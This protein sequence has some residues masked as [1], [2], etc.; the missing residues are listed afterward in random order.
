[1]FFLTVLYVH[2]GEILILQN[3][4]LLI[5]EM[6]FIFLQQ[7]QKN[8]EDIRETRACDYADMC[9]NSPWLHGHNVGKVVD[10]EDTT[11]TTQTSMANLEG[12]SLT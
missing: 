7:Q 3:V 8:V 2:R 1:M 4:V 5:Q 10:Y 9:R 11:M 6:I 12:L